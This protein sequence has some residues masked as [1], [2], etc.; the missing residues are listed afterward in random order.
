MKNILIALM[1]LALLLVLFPIRKDMLSKTNGGFKQDSNQPQPNCLVRVVTVS[2]DGLNE[3]SGK[4]RLD[5][6]IT[7]LNRAGCFRTIADKLHIRC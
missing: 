6:T 2:Q 3:K 7:R 4:P 1:L 5:A